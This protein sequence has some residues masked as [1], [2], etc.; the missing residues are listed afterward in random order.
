MSTLSVMV[1]LFDIRKT[2]TLKMTLK[3]DTEHASNRLSQIVSIT[4]VSNSDKL[5]NTY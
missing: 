5:K 3:Q 2:L 1:W 4:N